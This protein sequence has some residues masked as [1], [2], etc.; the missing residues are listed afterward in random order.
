MEQPITKVYIYPK[1]YY[2]NGEFRTYMAHQKYTCSNGK[3]GRKC[4]QLTDEQKQQ[5]TNY[6]EEGRTLSYISTALKLPRTAVVRF[7]NEQ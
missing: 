2:A 1:K 3:R 6:I 4:T 7:A 5:I